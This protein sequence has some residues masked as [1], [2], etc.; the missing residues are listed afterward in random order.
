[1]QNNDKMLILDKMLIED[2]MLIKD[3]MRPQ[4][5]PQDKSHDKTH[6]NDKRVNFQTT[7]FSNYKKSHVIKELTNSMYYQKL[8]EAFFWTGDLLCSGHII[9]IWNVYIHFICKYIHVNNPKL[10]IYLYKKF[11]EFKSIAVKSSDLELRNNKEVRILFFTITAMLCD[12]KKDSI[13][14]NL[15]FDLKD[16]HSNLKAPN[17]TYIQSFFRQGDPKEYFIALNELMYHL[18]DTKNKMDILYWIEWIIEFEQVLIKKKKHIVCIQ[19]DFAP[20]TNIIWLIWE[21]FLSFKHDPVLERIINA[22][23]NLFRIKYTPASN[24]KKKCILHLCIMFI[25]NHID[26]NK[27][28]VENVAIFNHLEKNIVITF[29]QI[30]KSES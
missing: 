13:L 20:N 11:E 22:L 3:K 29:E 12:S 10:P 4:D 8:E 9:D 18:K 24:K 7:T 2:K 19:R 27:K 25:I 28:L 21:L 17:I 23:F 14:D 26:Y 30:K 5:K 15:K 16:I 6:I 1:M